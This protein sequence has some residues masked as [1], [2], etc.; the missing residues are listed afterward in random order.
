MQDLALIGAMAVRVVRNALDFGQGEPGLVRFVIT[1]LSR[2]E[3]AAIAIAVQS[4]AS[5]RD[6]LEIALPE[7]GFANYPGINETSLTNR[8][9]TEL[10]HAECSREGRLIALLD[11][12]QGQSLAQ[13]DHLD[14]SALLNRD[15]AT[16]WISAVLGN[17]TVPEEYQIEMSAALD[18]LVQ[19]DRVSMRQ[20]A[21]YLVN[22]ADEIRK[23]EKL[24]VALGR[25]LPKLRLPRADTL[26]ED[27]KLEHRRRPSEWSKRY[28]K[29]WRREC[30]VAKRDLNQIPLS[31]AKLRDRLKAEAARL[32]EAAIST[33][34]R[35][36]EAPPE[37]RDAI[38][39]PFELDWPEIAPL[40]EE[41]Q[42]DTGRSIG[43]IGR[44]HV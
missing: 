4:D 31:T 21:N 33:L 28:Q 8:S 38:F 27:I 2:D 9:A 10:R 24:T 13:V 11:D 14:A 42:R 34:S 3:I 35:Y 36:V 32:S 18:A 40:F 20:V 29:H 16:E 17:L 5:I 30:F 39:A 7:Y 43:E 6:R 26:F 44:A 22:A 25:S 37:D 1:G 41:G 12:S 15:N 19:I 23:G